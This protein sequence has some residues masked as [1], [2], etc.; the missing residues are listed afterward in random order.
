MH[1]EARTYEEWITRDWENYIDG[2]KPG[3][4]RY[5]FPIPSEAI[6]N[7]QGTLTN[8]GYGF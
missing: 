5:V 1:D 7:S 6:L 8:D 3:V 4:V 2:I